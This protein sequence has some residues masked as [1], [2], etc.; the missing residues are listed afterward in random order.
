LGEECHLRHLRYTH[1]CLGRG[2]VPS[3]TWRLSLNRIDGDGARPSLRVAQVRLDH[4]DRIEF[5]G[6]SD[7]PVET[8]YFEYFELKY[9]DTSLT[10]AVVLA[11]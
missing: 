9:F 3:V 7:C 6:A 1:L 4:D 11:L 8:P 10:A 5:C 2:Y